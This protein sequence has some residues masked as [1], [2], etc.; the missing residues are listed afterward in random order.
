MPSQIKYYKNLKAIADRIIMD[1]TVEDIDRM[2]AQGGGDI[3]ALVRQLVQQS[4]DLARR[5][6]ELAQRVSDLVKRN[7][8]KRGIKGNFVLRFGLTCLGRN[9]LRL[10]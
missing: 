8:C 6:D 1:L 4:A 2:A 10:D 5:V 3:Y 7:A 9:I